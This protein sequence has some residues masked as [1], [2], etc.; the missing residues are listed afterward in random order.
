MTEL[1]LQGEDDKKVKVLWWPVRICDSEN[2][3]ACAS[4]NAVRMR[5]KHAEGQSACKFTHVRVRPHKRPLNEDAMS[6]V[7]SS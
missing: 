6:K 4:A 1:I 7:S 3:S 2:S 5:A